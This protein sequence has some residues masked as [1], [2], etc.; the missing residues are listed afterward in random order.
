MKK[1]SKNSICF[2]SRVTACLPCHSLYIQDNSFE[3]KMLFPYKSKP[4]SFEV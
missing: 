4:Y 3:L 1:V 2:K